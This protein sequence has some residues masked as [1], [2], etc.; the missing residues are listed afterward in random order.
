[1]S[2]AATVALLHTVLQILIVTPL[3][4]VELLFIATAYNK[5]IYKLFLLRPF[6]L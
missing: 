4:A 5:M 2:C 6:L 1:M 3:G